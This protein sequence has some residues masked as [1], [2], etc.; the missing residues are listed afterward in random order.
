[1][2]GLLS[3][4][5]VEIL[6]IDTVRLGRPAVRRDFALQLPTLA[7]GR[8]A[9]HGLDEPVEL[10]VNPPPHRC[11]ARRELRQ[12]HLRDICHL[13]D[14]MLGFLPARTQLRVSSARKLA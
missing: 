1:M 13:G 9:P 3:P 5:R 14:A 6:G 10:L 2:R 7:R 11:H 4:L 8:L 12:K